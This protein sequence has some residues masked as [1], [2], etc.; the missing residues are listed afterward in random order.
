MAA[1]NEPTGANPQQQADPG[2]APGRNDPMQASGEAPPVAT[3]PTGG[4]AQPANPVGDGRQAGPLSGNPPVSSAPAGGPTRDR[5]TVSPGD[6]GT[7]PAGVVNTAAPVGKPEIRPT[8]ELTR[9]PFPGVESADEP[10]RVGTNL[11]DVI[12]HFKDAT[13]AMTARQ[14]SNLSR[15]SGYLLIDFGDILDG[16]LSFMPRMIGAAPGQ[17][18][19]QAGQEELNRLRADF[20]KACAEFDREKPAALA[21]VPTVQHTGWH[22]AGGPV[23]GAAMPRATPQPARPVAGMVGV[24]LMS[25]NWLAILLE[26]APVVI[27]AVRRALAQS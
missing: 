17:D 1:P 23:S 24:P 16:N 11:S 10:G 4:N 8:D 12:T 7:M 27:D 13:A 25:P 3:S 6:V 15:A 2:T 22:Q 14:W 9:P 26:I 21:C 19:Q 18:V 20:D 5:Q